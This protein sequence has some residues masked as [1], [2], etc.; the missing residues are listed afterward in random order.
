MA[1][2]ALLGCRDSG[3]P[4][5]HERQPRAGARRRP[6]RCGWPPPWRASPTD[7]GA[8]TVIHDDEHG[9]YGHPDHRA[10]SR[11]GATAAELLGA[12]AYRMTVDREHLH[13]SARD[14]HLV[15][16]AARAAAVPFGRMTAEIPL[17]RRRDGRGATDQAGRDHR[18]REPDRRGRRARRR[19]RRRLRPRVVPPLRRRPACST[20]WATPTSS[21]ARPTPLTARAAAWRARRRPR[22]SRPVAPA[23]SAAHAWLVVAAPTADPAA[24]P[25]RRRRPSAAV[26]GSGW[27]RPSGRACCCT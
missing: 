21:A 4:G 10:T 22:R 20:P 11:V 2:L 18:A 14:R 6:T 23:P 9:I 8:D 7:E 24:A 3:L 5:W 15:H 13:V 26:R 1:R 25:P 27:P 16:G 17:A 12:S 19:V